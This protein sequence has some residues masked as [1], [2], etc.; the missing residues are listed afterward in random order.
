MTIKTIARNAVR[1][2]FL[3]EMAPKATERVHGGTGEAREAREWAESVAI[4]IPDWTTA[5]DSELWAEAQAFASKAKADGQ[6]KI[7]ELAAQGVRLG[8]GGAYDLMYFLTRYL[9]PTNVL[10]TGVAA[11]WTLV[12]S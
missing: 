4:E 6:A 12:R 2:G 3:P 9:K 8:G 1:P 7:A 11:G 10:E 5:L